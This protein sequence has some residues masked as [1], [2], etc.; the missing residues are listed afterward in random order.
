MV[1]HRVLFSSQLGI[2][3][4]VNLLR[5]NSVNPDLDPRIYLLEIWVM[6]AM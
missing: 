2:C 5:Y 6:V 3:R 1:G 4:S